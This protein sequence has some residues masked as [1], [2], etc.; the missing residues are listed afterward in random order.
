MNKF[1]LNDRVYFLCNNSIQAKLITDIHIIGKKKE[2][3]VYS[4]VIKY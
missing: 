2:T 4:Y 3:K 1:N